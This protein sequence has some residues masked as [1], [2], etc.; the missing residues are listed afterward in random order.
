MNFYW[1]TH[2]FTNENKNSLKLFIHTNTIASYYQIHL[3]CLKIV[4]K[5][6]FETIFIVLACPDK[7]ELDATKFSL[8]C[9]AFRYC[10]FF[11][12][13]FEVVLWCFTEFSDVLWLAPEVWEASLKWRFACFAPA[14][15]WL[16][17]LQLNSTRNPFSVRQ[18]TAN[19]SAILAL[20]RFRCFPIRRIYFHAVVF[21]CICNHL[22]AGSQWDFFIGFRTIT[23]EETI[24]K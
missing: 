11:V 15:C 18:R 8:R 4:N 19:I 5:I 22:M 9:E 23:G 17:A 20:F 21:H 7:K 3:R 16:V 2:S 1:K 12:A 14:S 13:C 6:N 24:E 10:I